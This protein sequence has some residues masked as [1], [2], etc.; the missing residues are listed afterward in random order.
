MMHTYCP[1]LWNSL[2]LDNRGNVYS[3]CLIKPVCIGNIYS[4]R[5]ERYGKFPEH[6]RGK[7][8]I[9]SRKA[10]MFFDV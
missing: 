8:K 10:R 2:T 3:C 7:G 5:L 1:E 4:T 6:R 9:V